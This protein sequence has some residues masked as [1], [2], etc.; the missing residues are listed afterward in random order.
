MPPKLTRY[1]KILLPRVRHKSLES[2]K[3]KLK[4][5]KKLQWRKSQLGVK[6]R[7]TLLRKRLLQKN[8]ARTTNSTSLY[9]SQRRLISAKPC[10]NP[11]IR[12]VAMPATAAK[13]YSRKTRSPLQST[14]RETCFKTPWCR[15]IILARCQRLPMAQR[16]LQQ[17][18]TAISF[19][20]SK[21]RRHRK[22]VNLEILRDQ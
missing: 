8:S 5:R 17:L 19:K 2:V 7:K 21:R 11:P 4:I 9:R 22:A 6:H 20:Y 16:L 12:R 14:K 10:R 15:S 3:P 13:Y 1:S 18:S